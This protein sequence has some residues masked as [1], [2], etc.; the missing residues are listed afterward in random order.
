VQSR[1]PRLA[2]G[3]TVA[4]LVGGAVTSVSAVRAVVLDRGDD[5][6]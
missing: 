6:A 3:I 2:T 1:R 4:F 5:A